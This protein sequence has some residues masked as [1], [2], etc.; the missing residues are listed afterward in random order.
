MRLEK[1]SFR[2]LNCQVI[3]FCH[4]HFLEYDNTHPFFIN[5]LTIDL[6]LSNSNLSE[7][8]QLIGTK[9]MT[10]FPYQDYIVT[11]KAK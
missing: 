4:Y 7:M 2:K 5:R 8:L 6:Q 11:N 1:C 3:L 10:A 9:N